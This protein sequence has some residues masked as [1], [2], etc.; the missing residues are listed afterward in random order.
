LGALAGHDVVQAV[1]VHIPAATR[2]LPSALVD[3]LNFA[4]SSATREQTVG[5]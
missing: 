2:A 3:D 4:R 1:A 5:G